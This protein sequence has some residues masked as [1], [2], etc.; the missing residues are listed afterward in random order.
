MDFVVISDD[1]LRD[2]VIGHFADGGNRD[3]RIVCFAV[4]RP[5]T[6]QYGN[7]PVKDIAAV[8]QI[9]HDAVLI[10]VKANRS[11]QRVLLRLYE[12]KNRDIYVITLYAL[13]K[14]CG[15]LHDGGLDAR[16][17]HHLTSQEDRPYL[18][19]LEAH[20]CDHCN[21]NCKA[22]N[23]FSPFVR[24]PKYADLVRFEQDIRILAERFSNIGRFF[25]LGGEPLLAPQLCCQM[26][27][28]FRRYFPGAELRVLTNAILVGQ[29]T[30][31]FWACIRENKA[32]V[33]ISLYPPMAPQLEQIEE[34]L[35]ES[36]VDYVIARTVRD[37]RKRWGRYPLEDERRNNELCGSAGC[38]YLRDGVIAKC[39]D[40][41]L[42]GNMDQQLVSRQNL[43]LAE[44]E[45]PWEMIRRLEAPID[46]CRKCSH[47]SE[48][49]IPWER[50]EG[51]PDAADWLLESSLEREKRQFA[52]KCEALRK[53]SED[54]SAQLQSLEDA[55][56]KAESEMTGLEARMAALQEDLGAK[57][58]KLQE[59][60]T[61][62]IRQREAGE[63]LRRSLSYRI[64][65]GFTYFPRRVRRLLT[66][67][68]PV[69]NM[70]GVYSVGRAAQKNAIELRD[71]CINYR[72]LNSTSVQKSV[73]RRKEKEVI[74]E[75]VRHV[76][77]TVEKGG[78]LG[79]IGRN[80]SGKSTLLRSIAGVF[81]PNAGEIDLMGH[82]VSLMAL[83]VGFK[84][85]LTGRENIVLSGMLLGFTEREI[86]ERMD[87]I[88]EFAEIGDFIDRPVRTYSS[89]MH[90]K[91]A[92]AITAMLETDIMLVDEV[93]SVGDERFR[94]KSLEKMRTLILDK[95][96]TV[97]IVSHDKATL[98]ELCD[99]IL[100]LHDG[101]VM[102]IGQPEEV[103]E[104][105][106]EF[107]S[108]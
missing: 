63:T 74:F 12:Q 8:S 44:I 53:E 52:E 87:E 3:H 17:V 95:D 56:N 83:G 71:V 32:I 68:Q 58:R 33:H 105:Y 85:V 61:E 13:D 11:L 57:E 69:R 2:Y 45:D 14:E 76:S 75:A 35:N 21:L 48:G 59:A 28:C 77:F 89:G 30:P 72:I 16:H 78:I 94:K 50:V 34:V 26:M 64:G 27:A 31:E 42:I 47:R 96:R 102:E 97:I 18:V 10:A 19:H 36:G 22:C 54:K 65:R 66:A 86:N 106:V 104:H 81:S 98:L 55:L 99:R 62:V 107:M 46:L 60:E 100:W 70:D 20:V 108:R 79:I 82:S 67:P 1:N 49:L 24:E 38:H 25:L 84:D 15:F 93:L 41:I 103:L 101:E 37:F 29:M 39:P 92:F 4:N 90:S 9:K 43:S 23:N 6:D 73:A 51:E 80:G 40:A 7:Y 88:I 91:L 5:K